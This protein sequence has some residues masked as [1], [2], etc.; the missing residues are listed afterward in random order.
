MVAKQRPIEDR[1]SGLFV[2]HYEKPSSDWNMRFL[3][4]YPT[5]MLTFLQSI[6]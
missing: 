1:N 2:S 6:R 5:A 4:L 3:T